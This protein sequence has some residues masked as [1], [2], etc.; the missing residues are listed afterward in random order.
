MAVCKTT[1]H[2]LLIVTKMLPSS[3]DFKHSMSTTVNVV[4]LENWNHYTLTSTSASG[5]NLATPFHEATLQLRYLTTPA[6]MQQDYK[7]SD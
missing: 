2:K 3:E 4:Q 6:R 1:K 7:T 5:Q